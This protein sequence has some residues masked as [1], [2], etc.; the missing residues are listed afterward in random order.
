MK[1]GHLFLLLSTLIPLS[2]WGEHRLP[3]PSRS[4]GPA[5]VSPSELFSLQP[6]DQSDLVFDVPLRAHN[7][8]EKADV[9]L[10]PANP[11]S[12]ETTDILKQFSDL[13][14]IQNPEQKKSKEECECLNAKYANEFPSD[15]EAKKKE[16]KEKLNKVILQSFSKK[17]I[18]D[19]SRNMEEAAFFLTKSSEM[20]TDEERAKYL[21]CNDSHIYNDMI[22]T[23]CEQKGITD[24]TFID[25]RKDYFLSATGTRM[26]KDLTFKDKLH[27]LSDDIQEIVYTDDKGKRVSYTR[28]EYDSGRI[29]LAH[30]SEEGQ[31]ADKLVKA[32]LS[33]PKLLSAFEEER[34]AS[35]STPVMNILA[36]IN[37][38]KT[39]PAFADLQDFV[40]NNEKLEKAFRFLMN[41]HPGFMNA[42]QD[43]SVFTRLAEYRKPEDSILTTLETNR[44]VLE[45]ILTQRC[46]AMVVEFAHAVC[47]KDEDLVNM[48][49]PADLE[50]LVHAS[51]G[52]DDLHELLICEMEDKQSYG[53]FVNLTSVYSKERKADYLEM[54][55]EPDLNKHTNMFTRTMLANQKK[56]FRDV[57]AKAAELGARISKSVSAGGISS[58]NVYAKAVTEGRAFSFGKPQMSKA[59]A[60]SYLKDANKFEDKRRA[61]RIVAEK[62]KNKDTKAIIPSDSGQVSTPVITPRAS[63]VAPRGQVSAPQTI[64][65]KQQ[66]TNHLAR[67]N[68]PVEVERAVSNV[69]PSALEEL[70]RLKTAEAAIL[71]QRFELESRRMELMQRKVD[72]LQAQ[73]DNP[74][75]PSTRPESRAEGRSEEFPA[76][77][78]VTR[79]PAR[80]ESAPVTSGTQSEGQSPSATSF[81]GTTITSSTQTTSERSIPTQAASEGALNLGLAQ[82]E[83]QEAIIKEEIKKL[84]ESDG[85]IATSF[86][87][88]KSRGITVIIDSKEVLVKFENLDQE[89]K[90]LLELKFAKKERDQQVSKLAVL[91]MLMNQNR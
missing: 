65:P 49:E 71:Q 63:V 85:P 35:Q 70:N 12:T 53:K 75:R 32:I 38:N 15:L 39:D 86:E 20:F 76:E 9:C 67:T 77:T 74:V 18:N 17:F 33:N 14:F 68:R 59:Q 81:Q 48:M 45:P 31:V 44:G 3:M 60:R 16:E 42:M 87:E 83:N 50:N 64:S 82:S 27:F 8:C 19:F 43:Q 4:G 37:K 52:F 5:I 1:K 66:L 29:G 62:S 78:T 89:T 88:I 11:L 34:A 21:Q 13:S 6:V 84:I 41:T 25:Q 24:K 23:V 36:V 80:Q 7:K 26:Q 46:S 2:T 91:R 28:F 72:E 61:E 47:T 69:T 79:F 30:S 55:L 51:G 57:M 54:L 22:Q 58:A 90:T 10:A 56:D 73:I 40:S